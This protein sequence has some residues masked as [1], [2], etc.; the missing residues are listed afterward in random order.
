[1][2][3]ELDLMDELVKEHLKSYQVWF[4][5]LPFPYSFFFELKPLSFL[6]GNIEETSLQPSILLP[7]K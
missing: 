6:S 5:R 7:E 4:A 2:S 1:M 3:K